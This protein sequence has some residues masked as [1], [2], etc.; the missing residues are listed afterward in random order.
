[1]LDKLEES[2]E[3]LERRSR[4]YGVHEDHQSPGHNVCVKVDGDELTSYFIDMGDFE[5]IEKGSLRR[6]KKSTKAKR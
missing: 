3:D 5:F 2:N 1:M 6:K 4:Q